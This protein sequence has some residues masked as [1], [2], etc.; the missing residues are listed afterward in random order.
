MRLLAN[1]HAVNPPEH[2]E[3]AV[4]KRQV[5]VLVRAPRFV[6]GG[7]RRPNEE[8]RPA[9]QVLV[10]SHLFGGNEKKGSSREE[11]SGNS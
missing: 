4:G 9:G 1:L 6:V 3:Q 8:H 10:D 5:E 2:E 7:G 11:V